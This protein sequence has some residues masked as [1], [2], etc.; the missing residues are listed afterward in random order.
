VGKVCLIR[1]CKVWH[2]RAWKKS[3]NLPCIYSKEK[4][5]VWIWKHEW[6]VAVF[7]SE[8]LFTK[9]LVWQYRL[10]HG[11]NNA[12]HYQGIYYKSYEYN[13]LHLLWCSYKCL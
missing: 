5:H 4:T 10:V 12:W 3:F 11:W 2:M 6:F 8:K 13:K 9:T 7:R 1:F